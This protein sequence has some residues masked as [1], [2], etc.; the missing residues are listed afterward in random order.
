M[1]TQS[2]FGGFGGAGGGG[3][4]GLDDAFPWGEPSLTSSPWAGRSQHGSPPRPGQTLPVGL[5]ATSRTLDMAA[6]RLNQLQQQQQQ[7]Q[8]C[9]TLWPTGSQPGPTIYRHHAQYATGPFA[10]G[11]KEVGVRR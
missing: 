1:E 5:S 9:Q 8:K 3:G 6:N 2:E 11:P 4:G 10:S 7:Q